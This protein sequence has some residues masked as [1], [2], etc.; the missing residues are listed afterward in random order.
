[1]RARDIAM[2]IPTVR[3][4]DPVAEALRVMAVRRLPGLIV[5]DNAN[6]PRLV[7]PGTQVLRL[8]VPSTYQDDPA[9][10]RA[11]DEQ[12]AAEFWYG[13]GDLT[14]GDCLPAKPTRLGTVPT[15]ATLLEV[16]ALMA[17]SH[18]PLVAVIDESG[19]L[20]GG[21]TLERL[22]TSLAVSSPS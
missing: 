15:D 8:V 11:I 9:L 3:V 12:H 22:V 16:A 10:C 6:R 4:E 13:F 14:V 18:S 17:R 1:M 19:M 2:I 20:T 5:V 7:L 21:I